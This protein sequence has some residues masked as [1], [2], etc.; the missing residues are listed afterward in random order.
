MVIYE[1]KTQDLCIQI[2]F[3]Y[4]CQDPLLCDTII[5]QVEFA[6]KCICHVDKTN[7]HSKSS[8]CSYAE[9]D[10]P[11]VSQQLDTLFCLDIGT[12]HPSIASLGHRMA[13]PSC[14][15]HHSITVWY[16]SWQAC[17]KARQQTAR[18]ERS[19]PPWDPGQSHH[20]LIEIR[21]LW[22]YKHWVT[23]GMLHEMQQ[24]YPS[25]WRI[26]SSFLFC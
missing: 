5:C 9:R 10:T 7:T 24:C 26:F 2:F 16:E 11:V 25:N 19:P 20:E 14:P 3:I 15:C 13:L 23:T 6:A 18:R 1:H 8:T 4:G 22:Y 12:F 21:I 17:L